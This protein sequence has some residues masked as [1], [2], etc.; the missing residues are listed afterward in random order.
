[1]N[2]KY[3]KKY[4]KYKQKYSKLKKKFKIKGGMPE[5]LIGVLSALPL[6]QSIFIY[7]LVNSNESLK[8]K[9]NYILQLKKER[10]TKI[11]NIVNDFSKK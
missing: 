6:T 9:I 8:N 7:N 5:I 2:N 11:Q 1:M 10:N 3:E 4:K